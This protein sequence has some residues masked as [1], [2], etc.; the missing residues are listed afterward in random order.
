M[1]VAMLHRKQ[2]QADLRRL[3]PAAFFQ[4][5]PEG[6]LTPDSFS[7]F[8]CKWEL[9]CLGDITC[10]PQPEFLHVGRKLPK[11]CINNSTSPPLRAF[12]IKRISKQGLGSNFY[13]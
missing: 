13:Q 9:A 7:R 12:L 6:S 3:L 1:K 11:A 2:K 4:K 5:L 8:D 10:G